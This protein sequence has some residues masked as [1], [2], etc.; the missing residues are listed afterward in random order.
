[1]KTILSLFLLVLVAA[2]QSGC[3]SSGA[4]SAPEDNHRQSVK[5]AGR[6]E[7]ASG[8]AGGQARY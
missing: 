7:R 8:D 2:L 3:S 1:M 4:L 6:P 5:S